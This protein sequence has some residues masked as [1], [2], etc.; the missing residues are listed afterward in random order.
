MAT[1]LGFF[2]WSLKKVLQSETDAFNRARIKIIFCILLFSLIK[3]SI[4]V[5]A[6]MVQGETFQLIRAIFIFLL[7][8]S[9]MKMLLSRPDQLKGISHFLIC[10]GV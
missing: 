6:M 10:G 5:P 1:G 9:L 2:N 3:V 4:A 7:Y 8:F